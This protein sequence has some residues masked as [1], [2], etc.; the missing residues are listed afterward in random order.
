MQVRGFNHDGL[1]GFVVRTTNWGRDEFKLVCEKEK[2]RLGLGHFLFW[3]CVR[4][5]NKLA[6]PVGPGTSQA[7]RSRDVLEVVMIHARANGPTS[8]GVFPLSHA[9][10][11][12]NSTA[13]MPL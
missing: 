3:K 1:V 7:T 8:L 9:A 13:F 12:E 11:V 5:L 4:L 6:R 2:K 10:L